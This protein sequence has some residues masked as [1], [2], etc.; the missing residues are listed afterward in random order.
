MNVGVNP[1]STPK[2]FFVNPFSTLEMFFVNQF[3]TLKMC[4]PCL[5]PSVLSH[6]GSA[7]LKGL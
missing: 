7:V 2:M 5:I 4:F 6:V 1:F 3:S